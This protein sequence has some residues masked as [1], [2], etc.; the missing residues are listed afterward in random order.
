M[1]RLLYSIM[2]AMFEDIVGMYVRRIG[3]VNILLSSTKL[4][5]HCLKS[6]LESG[7]GTALYWKTQTLVHFSNNG[8]CMLVLNPLPI[9]DILRSP[10]NIYMLTLDDWPKE[11]RALSLYL[12]LTISL[13][14]SRYVP[15]TARIG[16]LTALAINVLAT[17]VPSCKILATLHLQS[18]C[19]RTRPRVDNYFLR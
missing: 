3:L 19:N 10:K 13:G 1:H 12:S 8:Y 17:Y 16:P 5:S 4:R 2:V 11:S 18:R 7:L 9:V 15:T 14:C 6:M